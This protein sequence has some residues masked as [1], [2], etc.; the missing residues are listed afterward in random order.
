MVYSYYKA[1]RHMEN[2]V[3]E[4]FFRTNPFKG[5]YAVFAG[6]GTFLDYLIN[7]SFTEEEI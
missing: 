7:F 3:F 6:L 2:A 5:S 4:M 1:N